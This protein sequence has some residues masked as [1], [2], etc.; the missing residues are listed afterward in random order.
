MKFQ[1]KRLMALAVGASFTL[2]ASLS[3]TDRA[4]AAVRYPMK[5]KQIQINGQKY[6]APMGI[7]ANNTTYM[8]IWYVMQALKQLGVGS[9]WDGVSWKMSLPSY[10]T[11]TI[12]LSPHAVGSKKIFLNGALADKVNS[13]TYRDPDSH[14]ATTY[15]PIW[16]IMNV[17]NAANVH[18]SWNGTTWNLKYTQPT[19]TQPSA[20]ASG[21]TT[22]TATS[23]NV[24]ENWSNNGLELTMSNVPYTRGGNMIPVQGNVKGTFRGD[25][26]VFVSA[27]NNE[28]VYSIPVHADGTFAADVT[29]PYNGTVDVEIGVPQTADGNFGLSAN[30]VDEEFLN[31]EPSLSEQQ[32]SLLQSWMVNYNE[33]TE[34]ATLASQITA[35]DAT[36]YAKIR[37]VSNW[38]SANIDYNFPDAN[39]NVSEWHQATDTM[40]IRNGVCQDEASVVAAMLRSIGIPTEVAVGEAYDPSSGVDLGGHAWNRSTD[41]S[42]WFS[43]DPTWDQIYYQDNAIT[44]P[45]SVKDVYF[46]ISPAVFAKSHKPDPT[47][48]YGWTYINPIFR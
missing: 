7:V 24:Q 22:L 13:I 30:A 44:A 47:E 16:Y 10:M 2:C 21:I 35:N 12:K 4:Q 34:F 17:L 40:N 39:N 31:S 38:V 33:N 9:K 28:W 45:Q 23:G 8:P 46:D 26:A 20:G 37:D 6:I 29:L 1:R 19:T 32:M 18:S 5:Q 27:G 11:S 25:L 14:V 41:G 43:Y 36:Q 48:P 3:Q 42:R 15:V